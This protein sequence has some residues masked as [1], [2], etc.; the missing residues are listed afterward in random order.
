VPS[1]Q[2]NNFVV[3]SVKFTLDKGHYISELR[4]LQSNGAIRESN[5]GQN[6]F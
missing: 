5:E 4:E 2:L 3:I 6:T 1:E